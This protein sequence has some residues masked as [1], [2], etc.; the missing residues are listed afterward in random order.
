M[1]G[2]STP[3]FNPWEIIKVFLGACECLEDDG[4]FIIDEVDRRYG[5]FLTRGYQHLLAEGDEDKFVLSFHSGY[6]MLK[7]T[8]SR[9]HFNP[10]FPKKGVTMELFFWGLAEIGAFTFLFFKDVDFVNLDGTRHFILGYGP[11]RMLKSKDFRGP[12][13]FRKNK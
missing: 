3:H 10:I 2:L 5:I 8:F 11:R 9:T 1:Y 7:G 12:F 4:I 13:L 6:D